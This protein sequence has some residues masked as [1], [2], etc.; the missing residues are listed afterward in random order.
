MPGELTAQMSQSGGRW[1]LYVILRGR[2]GE[3]PQHWFAEGE[4]IPTFT[5]RTDTLTVLG[6]EPVPGSRWEWVEGS[7]DPAD[8]SS[9]IVLIAAIRVRSRAGVAA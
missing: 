8:P 4:P 9:P 5:Q 3:W 6:F 7:S 1:C 2:T